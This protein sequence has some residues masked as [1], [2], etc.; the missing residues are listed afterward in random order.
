MG[1]AKTTIGFSEPRPSDS[2][3]AGICG[4]ADGLSR[5]DLSPVGISHDTCSRIFSSSSHT[6]Q[7][8][9][10]AWAPSPHRRAW[11]GLP[12]TLR[13]HLKARE[14]R[15]PD[16]SLAL[17]LL[18]S[19]RAHKLAFRTADDVFP[20]LTDTLSTCWV[21]AARSG[22]SGWSIAERRGDEFISSSQ[23]EH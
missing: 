16:G 13:R 5:F 21:P 11:S 20:L 10:E 2:D 6:T 14:D 1:A 18:P 8:I 4:F 23:C 22:E 15:M 9:L 3:C 17:S 7:N 19:A 12:T